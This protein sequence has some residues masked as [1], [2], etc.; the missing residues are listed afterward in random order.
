MNAKLLYTSFFLLLFLSSCHDDLEI[1]T[2]IDE[3]VPSPEVIQES[4]GDI[5]GYV[6]DE[7][8]NPIANV[9]ISTYAENVKTDQYGVFRLENTKLDGN[10]TFIK[11]EHDAY[12]IGS[13]MIYP[14]N[15]LNHSYIQLLSLS[16]TGDFS[17]S[18]VSRSANSYSTLLIS[19]P[20]SNRAFAS[21][22][23]LL[24]A[25]AHIHFIYAGLLRLVKISFNEN[26]L[27]V[28]G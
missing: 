9:E 1:S 2:T 19:N 11:A 5:I 6:F 20:R 22:C 7:D 23:A 25:S 3:E 21:F 15:G 4:Q 27:W 17:S 12:I 16:Q 24:T 14:K 13:D 8:K 28:V 18:I 26:M 10:G